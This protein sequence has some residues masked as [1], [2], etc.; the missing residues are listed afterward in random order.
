MW[1]VF[2]VLQEYWS[3]HSTCALQTAGIR[4]SFHIRRDVDRMKIMGD[5]AAVFL[6][7]AGFMGARVMAMAVFHL[8]VVRMFTV[9]DWLQYRIDV[10]I[11][12]VVRRISKICKRLVVLFRQCGIQ[13]VATICKF[14]R[15]Q[16]QLD[17]RIERGLVTHDRGW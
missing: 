7:R 10:V 2:N 3:A 16:R 13:P 4:V 8:C 12:V 9:I 5:C 15:Q 11:A 14:M 6:H 1:L 17:C